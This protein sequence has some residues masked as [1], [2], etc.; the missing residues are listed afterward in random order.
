MVKLIE[1]YSS[2]QYEG[3]FILHRII[4]LMQLYPGLYQV[5]LTEEFKSSWAD[6]KTTF[7]VKTV[8]FTDSMEATLYFNQVKE[9]LCPVDKAKVEEDNE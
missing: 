5:V 9:G 6:S 2:S 3:W 1:Q 7:N 8:E 4:Y